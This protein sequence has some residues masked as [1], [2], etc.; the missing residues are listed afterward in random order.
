VVLLGWVVVPFAVAVLFTTLPFPRH[1][2]Y[3]LPPAIVL[4]AYA[5]VRTGAWLQRRLP[6][7]AAAPALTAAALLLLAPALRYDQRLLANPATTKYP[8]GDDLQYVTGTTAGQ[9]WPAVAEAIRARGRGSE[10]VIVHPSADSNIIQFLLGTESRYEVVPG[11]SPLARRAQFALYD[12]AT[13][14]LDGAAHSLARSRG[15]VPL[16]RFSR[17]RGGAVLTLYGPP[18]SEP[19]FA[20]GPGTIR[21]S[22]GG[23]LRIV[24]G[25]IQGGLRRTRA[26]ADG[27]SF[28]GWAANLRRPRPATF[29]LAFSGGRFLAAL[30]PTVDRPDIAAR[31]GEGTLQQSGYEFELPHARNLRVFAV[32]GGAASPLPIR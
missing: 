14:F 4:M 2:M 28:T 6:P 30:P 21:W 23:P 20:L 27:V 10:V 3:V 9:I 5:I 15:F 11:D 8:R 12:Q 26:D 29:L 1:I 22:T 17:P 19:P 16:R 25:A 7:R 13:G 31:T 24:P 32:E 18:R